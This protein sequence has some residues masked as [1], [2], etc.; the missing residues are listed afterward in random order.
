MVL[1]AKTSDKGHGTDR[2]NRYDTVLQENV[3]CVPGDGWVAQT[4]EPPQMRLPQGRQGR[5]SCI[6][7]PIAGLCMARSLTCRNLW[8]PHA[9]VRSA[10][11]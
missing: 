11:E 2:E 8:K 1:K 6:G 10:E 5:R 9:P 4:V 7:G 3:L